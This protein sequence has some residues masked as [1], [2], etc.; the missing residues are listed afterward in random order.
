MTPKTRALLPALALLLI[1]APAHATDDFVP[2][3][4]DDPALVEAWTAWD[5]KGI[6]DYTTTVKLSCF[7]P[8]SAAVRTAV[9]DGVVRKVTQDGRRLALRQ[10]HSMDQLFAMIRAASETAD[11]VEVTYTARGV[12]KSIAVDP[13]EM[14]ADE[15]AYYFV[16]LSRS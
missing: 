7:C 6:D 11:R 13:K 14:V 15:E 8:R 3:T 4:S 1:P 12:P 2:T 10:G 5:A 9:R 16:S